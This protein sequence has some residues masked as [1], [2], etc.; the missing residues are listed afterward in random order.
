[1][2]K[3]NLQILRT[4]DMK[5]ITR[6][7]TLKQLI[8]GVSSNLLSNRLHELEKIG[9]VKKVVS[10]KAQVKVGYVLDEKCNGLKKI[11]I[12]LED[13]IMS[14]QISNQKQINTFADSI[15]IDHMLDFLK[16]EVKDTEYQFIKDK[17]L[18]QSQ[19]GSNFID[20][21][22]RLQNIMLELYG[23]E[24]GSKILKKLNQSVN[25]IN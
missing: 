22:D 19:D 20:E 5:T 9:F 25:R 12:D 16:R 7:N 17:L 11:L 6:F 10:D 21:F 14:Y 8:P 24:L 3:W 18:L 1:M 15:L 23:E 13:W 4:L 2:K